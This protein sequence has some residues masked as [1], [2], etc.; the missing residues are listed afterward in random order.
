MTSQTER[1]FVALERR[2]VDEV[3]LYELVHRDGGSVD[4][5]LGFQDVLAGLVRAG[6]VERTDHLG[7]RSRDRGRF[8]LVGLTTAGAAAARDR[9]RVRALALEEEARRAER[10]ARLRFRWVARLLGALRRRFAR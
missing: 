4:D 10:R 3:Q 7:R 9:V 8:L 1:I 5:F 2:P 6:L